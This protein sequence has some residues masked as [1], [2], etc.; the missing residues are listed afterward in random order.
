[1]AKLVGLWDGVPHDFK[2][3]TV[4]VIIP[5]LNEARNLPHVA[6]RMPTGIDEIVFVDGNSVD[7]SVAVSREAMASAGKREG[8]TAYA[9]PDEASALEAPEG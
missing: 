7:D 3:P 2:R 9:D 4:S 8:G 1:M 6:A 5:A